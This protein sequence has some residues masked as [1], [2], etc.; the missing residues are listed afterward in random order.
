MLKLLL[1][2]LHQELFKSELTEVRVAVASLFVVFSLTQSQIRTH[3]LDAGRKL[4]HQGNGVFA[5]GRPVP[6]ASTCRKCK[7]VINLR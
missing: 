7:G 3:S 4:T 1:Q 2:L 6:T 5:S